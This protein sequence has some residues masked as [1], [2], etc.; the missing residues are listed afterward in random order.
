MSERPAVG[1]LATIMV[2]I[3]TRSSY[4]FTVTIQVTAIIIILVP[5]R[6]RNKRLMFSLDFIRENIFNDL[7]YFPLMS[8]G[9]RK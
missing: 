1:P 2:V 3:T 8:V 9:I 5:Q 7:E 6:I 4:C